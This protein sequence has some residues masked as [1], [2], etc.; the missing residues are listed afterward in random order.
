MKF[1]DYIFKNLDVDHFIED[2]KKHPRDNN[3]RFTQI[4]LKNVWDLNSIKNS[5]LPEYV[6]DKD[7]F[8]ID[9]VYHGKK[10]TDQKSIFYKF[11]KKYNKNLSDKNIFTFFKKTSIRNTWFQFNKRWSLQGDDWSTNKLDLSNPLLNLIDGDTDNL[12]NFST[13]IEMY[14]RDTVFFQKLK[15]FEVLNF[16][17]PHDYGGSGEHHLY[18]VFYKPKKLS[19]IFE[20]Y[21]DDEGNDDYD[22][23]VKK[24]KIDQKEIFKYTGKFTNKDYYRSYSV[25]KDIDKYWKSKEFKKPYNL[26][27]K[28]KYTPVKIQTYTKQEYF[29]KFKEDFSV[30]IKFIQ[31]DPQKYFDDIPP[32]FKNFD[33]LAKVIS[34]DWDQK[35]KTPLVKHKLFHYLM[36]KKKGFSDN[37]D[38]I[39]QIMYHC[40]DIEKFKGYL[41]NRILNE[42]SIMDELDVLG[43]FR[44][45]TKNFVKKVLSKNK[46]KL[47]D[48]AGNYIPKH[49]LNDPDI[50]ME[51]LKLDLDCM[52][53][54]G[55]KLRINERFMNKVKKL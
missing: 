38:F 28:T 32:S 21:T 31:Q 24:G 12:R 45:R 53:H 49:L 5:I 2:L 10:T 22:F 13:I 4:V 11:F 46:D 51:I 23:Y 29:K 41:D 18:S 6:K 15:G 25:Y 16:F 35:P 55:D 19:L 26:E 7:Y 30:S 39:N 1:I 50:M 47:N 42:K 17:G 48:L 36:T 8:S 9:N 44:N 52:I 14:F 37:K 40:N 20:I 34:N 3:F 33:L 54:I 43:L 27:I